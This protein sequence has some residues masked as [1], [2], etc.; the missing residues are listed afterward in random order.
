MKEERKEQQES[1]VWIGVGKRL[2]R[3]AENWDRV[4]TA[5]CESGWTGDDN[6]KAVDAV[7]RILKENP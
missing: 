5:L 2:L 3:K 1:K 6:E 4:F 7:I